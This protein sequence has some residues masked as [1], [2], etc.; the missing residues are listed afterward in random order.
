MTL[1]I[2]AFRFDRPLLEVCRNVL[3]FL[4]VLLVVLILVTSV[5]GLVIGAGG[6]G[7]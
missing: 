7:A 3:P 2:G 1:L 6:P 4:L 5:P